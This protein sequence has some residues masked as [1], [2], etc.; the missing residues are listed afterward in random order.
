[1]C[2][3]CPDEIREALF[4]WLSEGKSLRA[5]CAREDTPSRGAIFR[6]LK[7]DPEFQ[8]QYAFALQAG[9][10]AHGDRVAQVAEDVLE[11]RLDYR[12]ANSAITA[13]TWLAERQAPKVYSA[14]FLHS[15]IDGNNKPAE[16]L[17]TRD[18]ARRLAF[19]MAQGAYAPEDRS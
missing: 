16:E 18:F 11:E 5:F 14:K 2:P 4:D 8:L 19:S 15:V 6:W 3:T 7:D 9:G 1:M 10:M 12:A 13:L 17:D